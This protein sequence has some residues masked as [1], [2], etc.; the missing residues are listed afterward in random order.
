MNLPDGH[1]SGP[2]DDA[3]ALRGS[4]GAAEEAGGVR[5]ARILSILPDAARRGRY[6]RRQPGYSLSDRECETWA[7]ARPATSTDAARQNR[8]GPASRRGSRLP[9]AWAAAE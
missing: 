6:R 1:R 2:A 8:A 7:T 4:A 9:P 5:E 3:P